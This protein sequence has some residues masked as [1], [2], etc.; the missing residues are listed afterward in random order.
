MEEE[1]NAP[2][3]PER[4]VGEATITALTLVYS[5][6]M[7]GLGSRYS[8]GPVAHEKRMLTVTAVRDRVAEAGET[9]VVQ[10]VLGAVSNSL[11][12]A[13]FADLRS[14]SYLAPLARAFRLGA[15]TGQVLKNS[16]GASEMPDFSRALRLSGSAGALDEA[17]RMAAEMKGE[18][19]LREVM[20]FASARDPIARE[21]TRNYEVTRQLAEP[22][23]LSSLSRADSARA[24]LV[25]AYLEVL[26]EVPDL[27]IKE[28]AGQ[29]EADEVSRMARGVLKSGGI[30][31]KRGL[32]TISNLDGM[33]RDDPR[34]APTATEAP[35][36]AAAFLV[37]L[38]HGPQSLGHRL[39]PASG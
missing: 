19:T 35:L 9:P 10:T 3:V 39:Y 11:E 37:A 18:A 6:P 27:D 14:A 29:K 1:Q 15:S 28:R 24:V 5:A 17:F 13:G 31:S 22:A 2:A 26:S 7:P 4:L 23:L 36:V 32:Q 8:D 34:L 12:F 25:Q 38:T 30:Y 16:L 21:Y 33:L 20:R